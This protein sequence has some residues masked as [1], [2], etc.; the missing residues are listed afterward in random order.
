MEPRAVILLAVATGSLMSCGDNLEASGPFGGVPVTDTV[1]APGLSAP[2]DVVRDSFGVPHIYASTEADAAFANGYIQA[3]DR[4]SEMDLLRHF[5]EGRVAEIFG[6][7]DKDQIDNDLTMRMHRFHEFADESLAQLQASSDPIDRAVVDELQRYADGV[8]Q[9][10][11]ELVAGNHTI[12]DEVAVFFD[13]SRFQTWTPTDS[14]AIGYLQQW[15][16]QYDDSE[17]ELQSFFDAA[18]SKF[19]QSGNADLARRAGAGIDLR[20]FAPIDPTST[21]DGFPNVDVDTGTRAK[22]ARSRK[23]PV[24][25]EALLAAGRRALAPDN[26]LFRA[27]KNP[28][29]GSN[30]WVVGPSLTG[31]GPILAN[32]PHL[33]LINPPVWHLLHITVPD[34]LDVTGVSFPG[35]PGIILGH[36]AHVAWG[37]TVVSHDA[38]DFYLETIAPCTSGTGDCVQ[39]EGNEVPLQQFTEQIDIGALGTITDSQTVTYEL[40]PHHGPILPVVQNHAVVPR[41]G[42]QGISVRYTGYGPSFAVRALYRL[43]HAAS[44]A[45]AFDALDDFTFGGQNWVIVDDAGSI[46]WTSTNQIPLRTPG[47]HAFDAK[48][49]PTGL[50]PFFVLPGDGSCEWQGF[51]DARYIPHAIDPASGFL[52]SANQDPVGETFDNNPLNGPMVDGRPLYAGWDY[53]PGLREGRITR[54]LQTLAAS[55]QP[56]TV[57][58]LASIQAD[59]HSNFG[60]LLRPS[61]VAAVTA[62]DEEIATPGTHPD[63]A[64][65]V[66]SMSS[67]RRTRM[68]D[69]GARLAAW[70][71]ETPPA[72][73]GSPSASEI[74]DSA[75]TSIFN[76]WAVSFMTHAFRDEEIALGRTADVDRAAVLVLAHP[77]KLTSE[78]A[79]E[80]G[81]S[82]LCDDLDTAGTIESCRLEVVIA[83]DEALGRLADPGTGFGSADPTNWRWGKLHTLTLSPL[84]PS[85]M[86]DIPTAT[87]PDPLLREGFPRPGD[88]YSVDASHPGTRDLDFTYDHGPS[89]RHLT[90]FDGPGQPHTRIALPGGQVFDRSSPHYRDL[91]DTYWRHNQYFDLPFTIDE[92]IGKAESHTR[93]VGP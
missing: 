41:S 43:N 63:L 37:A 18:R 58:D 86:L 4:I 67:A 66:S 3:A 17:L 75:A 8:N 38:D 21:I 82:I 19:D 20:Q 39:F 72:V 26:P 79:S 22:P 77:E 31:G 10:V 81:E 46:G 24:V 76:F 78:I 28:A 23:R 32:D 1:T 88:N 6:A 60:E 14:L 57:D 53:D 71:L 65:F 61:I 29:N 5:A 34:K 2:V 87:D 12:D 40:V 80:T 25:P 44:R 68:H 83:L 59:T 62:V 36:N 30:N 33:Q 70:T 93:F 49:N 42:A 11:D 9:Y 54:R 48:T 13:A 15:S 85:S 47:C 90:Q 55:D 27:I 56:I 35:I 45:E 84:T 52:A 50:A 51:M 91:M 7:L 74:A 64:A 16:L 73:E 69:A 89:M 92:I